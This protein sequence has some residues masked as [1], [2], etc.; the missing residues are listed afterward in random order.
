MRRAVVL[1]H[2]QQMLRSPD[3][4]AQRRPHQQKPKSI[5]AFIQIIGSSLLFISNLLNHYGV[6]RMKGLERFSK[7]LEIL[8]VPAK[9]MAKPQTIE[10]FKE[11]YRWMG[12]NIFRDFKIHHEVKEEITKFGKEYERVPMEIKRGLKK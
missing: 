1:V 12:D 5:P 9:P 7:H 4:G 3:G 8:S 2:G 11:L 6:K 10:F